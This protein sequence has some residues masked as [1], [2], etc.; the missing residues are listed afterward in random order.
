MQ[1]NTQLASP[2]IL[3]LVRPISGTNIVENGSKKQGDNV[4]SFQKGYALTLWVVQEK[5]GFT[6]E[7]AIFF[8]SGRFRIAG[9]NDPREEWFGL[10]PEQRDEWEQYLDALCPR[11][12]YEKYIAPIKYNCVDYNFDGL[13]F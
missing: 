7:E 8:A 11:K 3:K 1:S 2:G 9:L 10:T 13:L 12:E 4:P 5:F 6:Y